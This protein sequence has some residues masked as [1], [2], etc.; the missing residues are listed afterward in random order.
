MI[1]IFEGIVDTGKST[2]INHWLSTYG[3]SGTAL[4]KRINTKDTCADWLS[5]I[6]N[7][8]DVCMNM[9]EVLHAS[10][11][12]VNVIHDRFHVS[13]SFQLNEEH[14]EISKLSDRL[15]DI[16]TVLIYTY[17]SD[18][19]VLRARL[20][21]RNKSEDI[22][23]LHAKYEAAMNAIEINSKLRVIRLDTS[24]HDVESCCRK[25]AHGIL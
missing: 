13:T 24:K 21:D 7:S 10:G 6:R 22:E 15:H 5:F 9:Y 2:V 14:M 11:Q 19:N 23:S 4:Y 25:I 20:K 18:L 17:C 1:L 12:H 8:R 3:S 16:G